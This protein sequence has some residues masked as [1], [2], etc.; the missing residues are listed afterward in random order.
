MVPCCLK[1]ISREEH[2]RLVEENAKRP[3]LG[4]AWGKHHV[5][6]GN[7]KKAHQILTGTSCIQVHERYI[8]TSIPSQIISKYSFT[9]FKMIENELE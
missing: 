2:D 3:L 5:C 7:A 4:G 9:Q 1:I 6:P 8:L